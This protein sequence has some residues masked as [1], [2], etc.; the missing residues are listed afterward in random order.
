MLPLPL[1]WWWSVVKGVCSAVSRL[2][3]ASKCSLAMV[4]RVSGE[5]QYS[6]SLKQYVNADTQEVTDLHT[7]IVL[8]IWSRSMF[9]DMR[10]FV[11]I[12][13]FDTTI[14]KSILANRLN[15]VW[16]EV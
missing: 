5:G 4:E 2:A 8:V 7:V 3:E 6:S 14:R 1:T 13:F 16:N 12:N 10:H 11:S 9:A 15:T